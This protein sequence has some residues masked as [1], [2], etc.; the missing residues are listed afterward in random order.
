MGRLLEVTNIR[1]RISNKLKTCERHKV[2]YKSVK[3]IKKWQLETVKYIFMQSARKEKKLDNKWLFRPYF[4]QKGKSLKRSLYKSG[5]D[6][7][8]HEESKSITRACTYL[9]MIYNGTFL[10]LVNL[11][12]FINN[13]VLENCFIEKAITKLL[14]C[15]KDTKKINLFILKCVSN[16]ARIILSFNDPLLSLKDKWP[17]NI[18]AFFLDNSHSVD[19]AVPWFLL[20]YYRPQYDKNNA[21]IQ[22]ANKKKI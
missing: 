4:Y 18:D 19:Q 5:L 2:V 14:L 15:E 16:Y 10:Y 20:F 8:L 6:R 9:E 11:P 3:R 13:D 21:N 7:F 12:D 17:T 1:A 22:K